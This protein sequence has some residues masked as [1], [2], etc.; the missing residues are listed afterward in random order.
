MYIISVIDLLV[1]VCI[2][3][4][5]LYHII[6]PLLFNRCYIVLFQ[7]YLIIFFILF[8][9]HVYSPTHSVVSICLWIKVSDFRLSCESYGLGAC[10]PHMAGPC[11]VACP[12][13]LVVPTFTLP[14]IGCY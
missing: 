12:L 7:I 14:L 5:P 4:S 6:Y 13:F 9:F 3:I 8:C 11:G 1:L 2:F 10:L